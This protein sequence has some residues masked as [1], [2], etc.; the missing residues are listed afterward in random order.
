[1]K[2]VARLLDGEA[3]GI[4]FDNPWAIRNPLDEA[5]D[6]YRMFRSGS[7]SIDEIRQ[8]IAVPKAIEEALLAYAECY[9]NDGRQVYRVLLFRESVAK[10]F[11]RLIE[12][13]QS[14]PES[15]QVSVEEPAGGGLAN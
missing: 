4:S 11:E 6:L 5:R 14:F 3:L 1:M 10:E 9:P 13:D 12:R 15:S 2:S 7:C 8:L